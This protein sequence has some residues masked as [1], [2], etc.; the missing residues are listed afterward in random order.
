MK[1]PD[2]L[3]VGAQKAGTSSLRK[4]LE[5]NSELFFTPRRELHFWNRDQQY[6]DGDGVRD[7]LRN[8]SE[9]KDSQ[10]IGEKSPSYLPSISA[11]Q[12]I[13]LH[14]PG[15]KIIAILRDPA[16]RAYSAYL[17]GRRIGAIPKDRTFSTAIR[18]YKERGGIPY[19]DVVSQGFYFNSL[20]R[21]YDNFDKKQIHVVGFSELTSKS[22]Q[23]LLRFMEF[24]TPEDFNFRS[25]E[26][27]YTMPKVNVARSS[28]FPGLVRRI[29]GSKHLS[30]EQK[31]YLSGLTF[32][33]I[34]E[35]MMKQEDR[36]YLDKLYREQNSL[37]K[38]LL[39]QDFL[40]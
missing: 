30:L 21:Y 26:I 22:E 12:R 32:K 11:A 5:R 35:P 16:D 4:F 18:D 19:G 2:F 37:L 25:M 1:T 14:L 3:I 7:Y 15:V 23:T 13:S 9:A 33:K 34:K 29:R 17:H 36:I 6:R 39:G 40:Y 31:N 20:K 10:L 27:D 8:F 28:R 38:L 24:V